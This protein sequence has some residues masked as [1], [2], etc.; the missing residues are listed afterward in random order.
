MENVLNVFNLSGIQWI[1]I[2]I[3]ALFIG[4]SKT[5]LSGTGILIVPIMA[6]IFGGKASSGIVLPM[7]VFA[8]FIAVGKYKNHAEWKYILKLLPWAFLGIILG[9]LTGNFIDDSIFK[10]IIGII[11]IICLIIMSWML[12]HKENPF[13]PS[14]WYITT[15]LG[16]LSGFSTMIGNAAGPIMTIYLLSIGLP[17]FAFIG[18]CAWFFMIINLIKLPFQIIFWN[19]ITI[20]TL[21]LNM[22]LIPAIIFGAFIGILAVKNI[23]E[24]PFKIIIIVLTVI[25]AFKLFF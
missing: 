12:S 4:F 17:K 1:L 24:K 18:T 21:T 25:S 23:P 3:C 16:L 15:I 8:D 11:I 22:I 19:G 5:G 14:K 20:Q 10:K 2:I 7:L 9:L 13:I 6:G